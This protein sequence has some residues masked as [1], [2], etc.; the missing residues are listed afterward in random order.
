MVKHVV[1]LWIVPFLCAWT[2][3]AQAELLIFDSAD[4]WRTWQ[5]PHGLVQIDKAGELRLV[6]FRKEINA[7]ADA[8][9]FTHVTQERGEVS[10]GIWAAGSNPS[11]AAN[12]I[13]GDPATYWK[14]DP[15]SQQEDWFVDID[16]GRAVLARQI[17]LTFPDREGARPFRQFTVYA[18]TGAR[19]IA[20]EDVFEFIPVYR[21]SQENRA[22][23]I[24]IPLSYIGTDSTLVLDEGMDVDPVYES[25]YQVVQYISIV[26]EEQSEDAALVEV[27][28]IGV[29][30]NVSL[31]TQQR[32]FFFN[33]LVAV[34]PHNLFDGDMNT[35]SMVTSG[36]EGEGG[37]QMDW[38]GAG[39]WWGV[40]L[41]AVFFIDN[42][43]FYYQNRGEGVSSFIWFNSSS[44]PGHRILYS[45]GERSIGTGLPVTQALD[46]TELVTH[47]NPSGDDLFQIR[48]MFKP[49]KMRH[50]FWHGT[51]P[52]NWAEARTMEC[53]LFSPGHPAQVTLVSDFIDLGAISGD[54]RPKVVKAIHWN[55]DLPADTRLRLRSR[56]G[57]TM[58]SVYTFYDKKGTPV[59]EEKWNSSPKVIRGPIDTTIAIGEDWGAWSNVYQFSGETFQSDSPRRFVQLE[60]ILSSEDPDVAPLVRSLSIEYEDALLQEAKGSIL[61]RQTRPNVDTHFTYTLWPTADSEDSGFDLL[62]LTIP[63]L[64]DVQD[65][66]VRAGERQIT[67][68]QLS[69]LADSLL[70]ALPAKILGDSLQLDFTTRVFQNA[71]LFALDLGDSDRPEL[72]QSVVPAERRSNIVLLPELADSD[73]LLGDLRISSP[74]LT[75]NGDGINDRVDV[76]FVVYKLISAAPRAQIYDLSGRLVAAM[77]QTL[78]TSTHRTYTWSGRDLSE[79]LVPPGVYLCRVD[80][81]AAAG[82]DTELRAISVAY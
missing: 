50:I 12:V 19:I 73:R 51:T 56:S 18:T 54:Q 72:W 38:E 32:G 24:V 53:M 4:Q 14:P 33:G 15:A 46:Y 13:D 77:E 66:A 47:I 61:P 45:A 78:A 76:D 37:E 30:D 25:D 62:R 31:G 28:V 21:T 75:P 49:R 43:F 42:F 40:D 67:P 10:G 55:A 59:T 52:L 11:S 9:L 29:G 26:A 48:Y 22:T 2:G 70:I 35:F 23:S 7:A 71:T 3:T 1:P 16:L 8:H 36:H 69:T 44:G 80:L 81:E 68:S 20:T 74:V 63:N 41:G 34:T 82:E 6:K 79:A 58:E 60:M 5:M 57:N 39:T 27:E 64:R 65:V 17:R